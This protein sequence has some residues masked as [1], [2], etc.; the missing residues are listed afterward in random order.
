MKTVTFNV[1]KIDETE[2]WVDP[3]K[4]HGPIWSIYFYD[5]NQV[6]HLCELTPSYYLH[7]LYY[8]ADK[9]LPENIQDDIDEVARNWDDKGIYVWCHQIPPTIASEEFELDVEDY[10]DDYNGFSDDDYTTDDESA[11]YRAAEEAAM[12][13]WQGNWP[14]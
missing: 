3:I 12:E 5:P 4:E 14:Y 1:V 6:T 7:F 10:S 8:T 11:A 2:D 13:Y 9:E